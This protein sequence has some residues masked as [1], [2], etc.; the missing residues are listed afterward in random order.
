MFVPPRFRSLE[1]IIT[2]YIR[3]LSITR[4]VLRSGPS[5]SMPYVESGTHLSCILFCVW[6]T[7]RNL[8]DSSVR[9]ARHAVIQSVELLGQ[10][11]ARQIKAVSWTRHVCC[12][13]RQ[14]FGR[15]QFPSFE[16]VGGIGVQQAESP[17]AGIV[18][19]LLQP[20]EFVGH[21]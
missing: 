2:I 16:K 1:G 17:A 5:P 18:P 12:Q 9:H 14:V 21:G 20:A 13:P 6:H 19:R 4:S 10:R 8:T 3:R 15:R 11:H 7:A